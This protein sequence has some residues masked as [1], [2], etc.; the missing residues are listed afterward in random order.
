LITHTS[1]KLQR[2]AWDRQRFEA[3]LTAARAAA[4]SVL[5]ARTHL[6]VS[7]NGGLQFRREL[8]PDLRLQRSKLSVRQRLRPCF[9]EATGSSC[10]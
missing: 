4:A 8:E 5:N 7:S 10:Y 9:A 1:T 6:L 3:S 2:A